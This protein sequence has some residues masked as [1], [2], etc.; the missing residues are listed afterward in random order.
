MCAENRDKLRVR[1]NM[2]GVICFF[3]TGGKFIFNSLL[4]RRD[5]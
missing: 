4:R 2:R 1:V 3:G 5:G